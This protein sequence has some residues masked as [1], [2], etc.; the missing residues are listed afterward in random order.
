MRR[1]AVSPRERTKFGARPTA[2]YASRAEAERA[3]ELRLLA[4]AGAIA[5]L[6][7]QPLLD[8]HPDG[9]RPIR[10]RADFRYREGGRVVVEDVKSPATMTD[11]FRLKWKLLAWKYPACVRRISLRRRAGGFEI[12]DEEG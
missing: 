2:G 10:Y 7:E 3:A 1:R 6:E 9:C 12:R 4:R 5:D 11:V 8:V